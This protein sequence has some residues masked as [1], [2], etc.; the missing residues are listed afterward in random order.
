ME[1]NPGVFWEAIEREM[2]RGGVVFYRYNRV[3]DMERT[4]SVLEELGSDASIG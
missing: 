4:V 1:Q 2:E 3:E